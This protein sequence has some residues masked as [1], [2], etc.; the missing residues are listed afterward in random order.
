MISLQMQPFLI[1][2]YPHHLSSF[3]SQFFHQPGLFCPDTIAIIPDCPC[4][5]RLAPFSSATICHN[6]N[7][8]L[9]DSRGYYLSAPW[10]NIQ[11]ISWVGRQ[12]CGWFGRKWMCCEC[13]P[14]VALFE[15]ACSLF[16]MGRFFSPH[17]RT[18]TCETNEV[19]LISSAY[20]M[21]R[22]FKNECWFEHLFEPALCWT[23]HTLNAPH[24]KRRLFSNQG[25]A[26]V[27]W[28]KNFVF[29]CPLLMST[30]AFY[31]A[32]WNISLS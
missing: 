6:L 1:F 20:E 16:K 26:S 29:W 14:L 2:L 11:Y 8:T 12:C 4:L 25:W 32:L 5:H 30:Y 23:H 31:F 7:Y 9:K 18:H 3:S 21:D 19:R 24:F 27:K 17:M 22:V 28:N 15:M 13:D 10:K